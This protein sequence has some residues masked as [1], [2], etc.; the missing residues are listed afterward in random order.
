MAGS[1][2]SILLI[3]FTCVKPCQWIKKLW[4]AH[5]ISIAVKFCI[6]NLKSEEKNQTGLLITVPEHQ[7]K[8]KKRSEKV[9]RL[10]EKTKL[11]H[12]RLVILLRLFSLMETGA[13]PLLHFCHF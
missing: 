4:P 7:Q 12:K 8:W 5:I 11:N 9:S 2:H 3:I 1:Q 10:Q 13:S 6:I